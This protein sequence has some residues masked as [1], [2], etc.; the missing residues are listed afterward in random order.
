MTDMITADAKIY[1]DDAERLA[2][3]SVHVS[4]HPFPNTC[5]RKG[6]VAIYCHDDHFTVLVHRRGDHAL[7][8]Y[9]V[10]TIEDA[11]DIAERQPA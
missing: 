7:R 10:T 9:R 8:D 6:D 4:I 5:L 2:G 3:Y 1:L 11:L